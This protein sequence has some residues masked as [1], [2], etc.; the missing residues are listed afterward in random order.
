MP[1]AMTQKPS[2]SSIAKQSS[3]VGRTRPLSVMPYAASTMHAG[4]VRLQPPFDM[5]QGG[6]EPAE[7]PDRSHLSRAERSNFASSICSVLR[8]VPLGTRYTKS[9]EYS[10]TDPTSTN[11]TEVL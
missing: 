8:T 3:L 1:S 2:G 11:C 4:S 9:H 10:G 6:L 7:R 5:A